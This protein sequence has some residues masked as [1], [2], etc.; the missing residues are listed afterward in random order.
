MAKAR[1]E[2]LVVL[3][4]TNETSNMTFQ[5]RTSYLPN[6]IL[7]GHRFESMLLYRKDHN[8]FQV[9]FSAFH[10]TYE[11][12]TPI[13]SA[14]TLK[15][16][17]DTTTK[18]KISGIKR[19]P[20]SMINAV[21]QVMLDKKKKISRQPFTAEYFVETPLSRSM[22]NSN[23]LSSNK[24]Q[25]LRK[26]RSMT[27]LSSKLSRTLDNNQTAE[28]KV[29]WMLGAQVSPNNHINNSLPPIDLTEDSESSVDSAN[30]IEAKKL[31]SS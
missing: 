10:S 29:Q 19:R 23:P 6:E 26:Q 21:T 3:E 28:E 25:S 11:V 17:H 27:A 22:S 15:D 30:A 9:N 16:F 24:T 31:Q 13:C 1:F 14:R 4:G 20:R 12:D 18:R 7:W 2:L 8:K 5:A